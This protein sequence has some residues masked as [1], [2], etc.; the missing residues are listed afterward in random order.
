[1]IDQ[2]RPNS[3]YN[4]IY[5]KNSYALAKELKC[6]RAKISY[7]HKKGHLRY[8]EIPSKNTLSQ[9]EKV[10]IRIIRLM[11]NLNSRCE[12]INDIKYKCYGGKGIK[13]LLSLDDIIYL[14]NRDDASKMIQ[15]SIDRKNNKKD[16]ILENCQFIEMEENR[17]KKMKK[18][19]RVHKDTIDFMLNNIPNDL[20]REFHSKCSGEG[21]F[22]RGVIL[23]LIQNNIK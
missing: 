12:N 18:K 15:P 1:M 5:G 2:Y 11:G 10:D 7:L 22:M 21:K 16:Y 23:E 6:T 17:R 9:L 20:W 19:P 4:R 14:W 8:L 13:N 3:K